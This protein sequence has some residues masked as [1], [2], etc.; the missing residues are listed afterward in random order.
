MSIRSWPALLLFTAACDLGAEEIPAV[1]RPEEGYVIDGDLPAD[2]DLDE[3][4][5]QMVPG[6]F[7]ILGDPQ[8]GEVATVRM[9]GDSAWRIANSDFTITSGPVCTNCGT[10]C[11]PTSRTIRIVLNHATGMDG[12]QFFV[13]PI[14]SR[15]FT[16]AATSPGAFTSLV[17][18]DVTLDTTGDVTSCTQTFA[19]LFELTAQPRVFVTS[20]SYSGNLGGVAGADAKC[21]ARADAAGLGGTWKAWLASSADGLPA[22]RFTYADPWVKVNSNV[23]VADDLGDL[24]DGTIDSLINVTE[25]GTAVNPFNK[26]VWTGITAPNSIAAET[27]NGWTNGTASFSGR[28]GSAARQ[29]TQWEDAGL[30]GCNMANGLYCFEQ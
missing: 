27:C 15:N 10:G 4:L 6:S 1:P 28:R 7:A 2:A 21:Q 20:T 25:F 13:N 5:S 18:A 11:P 26:I 29:N 9:A 8:T 16:G 24:T 19:Y 30:S 12:E 22:P 14:Y 17:G 23:K 3:V